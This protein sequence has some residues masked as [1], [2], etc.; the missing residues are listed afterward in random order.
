LLTIVPFFK[1]CFSRLTTKNS[2]IMKR[3]YRYVPLLELQLPLSL[4]SVRPAVCHVV[5]DAFVASKRSQRVAFSYGYTV[6][7]GTLSPKTL[8]AAIGWPSSVWHRLHFPGQEV[9]VTSVTAPLSLHRVRFVTPS[10]FSPAV[11]TFYNRNGATY[12][13]RMA[14]KYG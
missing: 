7:I 9:H 3:N 6:N 5:V 11:N 14:L 2:W 10:Y 8:Q 12:D 13:V 4:F 1:K